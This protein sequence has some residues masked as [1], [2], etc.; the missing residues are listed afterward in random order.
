[1]ITP[2]PIE[3]TMVLLIVYLGIICLLKFAYNL[4][5]KIDSYYNLKDKTKHN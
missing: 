4:G 3:D 2:M 1:M 5:G